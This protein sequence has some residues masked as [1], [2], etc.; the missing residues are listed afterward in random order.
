MVGKVRAQTHKDA[1]RQLSSLLVRVNQI[2]RGWAFYFRHG[3]SQAV[4][5]YLRAFAWRRVTMW[6]RKLH[7]GVSWKKLLRRAFKGPGKW[8]IS[9]GGITLF[10]PTTIPSTRYRYRGAKIPTPWSA[11]V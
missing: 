10:D 6:L 4:F 9:A 11:A 7:K 2:V 3:V 1:H 5:G 8:G